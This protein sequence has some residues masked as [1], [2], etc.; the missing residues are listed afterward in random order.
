MTGRGFGCDIT[1]LIAV[2]F[3]FI[4]IKNGEVV[5]RK[6]IKNKFLRDQARRFASWYYY[7]IGNVWKDQRPVWYVNLIKTINLTVSSYLD[8]NIQSRASSL[9]YS[10]LLAIVPALALMFAVARGFGF[11]DAIIGELHYIFPSQG[12]MIDA[13]TK[14]VDSYLAAASGGVF[15]GVGIVLLLWTLIS[16]LRNIEMTFNH[17]WGVKRGRSPYRMVTDYITIIIVLPILMICSSGISLVMSSFM[18][19]TVG[20]GSMLSPLLRI[21][22]DVAPWILAC[23]FFAGMYVLIPYTKVKFKYA[24]ISGTICGLLFQLVQYVF[25]S[26]QM[27]VSKYNAIYGSFS[28]LPLFLIWLY[29]T[30]L[31]C[32]AG[33]VLT[34][35][36]QNIFRFSYLS[37]VAQISSSYKDEIVMYVV[38]VLVKR[39]EEGNPPYTKHRLM[40]SHNLPIRLVN[41]II[42]KL[43]DAG[44]LSMVLDGTGEHA[45]QPARNL[46]EMT[47]EDFM[48]TYHNIGISNF[49]PELR[50]NSGFQKVSELLGHRGTPVSHL[51][52]KELVHSDIYK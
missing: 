10:T 39:F 8:K 1:R 18:Q 43:V 17:I 11:Q 26:G 5:K 19:N 25:V 33:V 31:I 32:I 41:D 35:A 4:R 36:A 48:R 21:V 7:C 23:L 9:T 13:A 46:T 40:E 34:Y 24:L 16:L 45:Y 52:I 42:D 44:I 37:Q 30:W 15:V 6:P 14:F 27:Y 51:P 12:T 28:F 49:I 20:L 47:V 2:L 29:L 22:L 38:L 50:K 3:F